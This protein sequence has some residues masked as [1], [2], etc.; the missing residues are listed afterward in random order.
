MNNFFSLSEELFHISKREEYI[1]LYV[2]MNRKYESKKDEAGSA[3]TSA[4]CI[5]ELS[6]ERMNLMINIRNHLRNLRLLFRDVLR[7]ENQLEPL[8]FRQI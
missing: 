7:Q 2:A 1:I 3:M 6:I 8:P 4:S 5:D